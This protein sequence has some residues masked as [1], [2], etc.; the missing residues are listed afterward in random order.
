[1]KTKAYGDTCLLQINVGDKIQLISNGIEVRVT[2]LYACP[3]GVNH[4]EIILVVEGKALTGG[5]CVRA[6]SDMFQAIEGEHYQ[7][8]GSL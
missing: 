4:P 5:G 3:N 6:T 1:M 7:Y 2:G 8:V